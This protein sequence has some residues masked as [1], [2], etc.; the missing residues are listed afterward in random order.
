MSN[1]QISQ[2]NPK[3]TPVAATDQFGIDDNLAVAYKI[4]VANLQV[5]F[6]GQYVPITGGTMTGFLILNANPVLALGAATKQYVDSQVVSGGS[7]RVAW[8]ATTANL[9]AIY[10]NGT[11]G[12]GRT[13]TN[14]GA[15][16]TLSIDSVALTVGKK[17]LVKDQSSTFQN[18]LY[19]V[20]DI[21]SGATNWVLTGDELADTANEMIPGSETTI[22]Y[23]TVNSL[24]Q[25]L[26][27][28]TVV[29]VGTDPV[30]YQ[31]NIVAGTGLTRTNNTIALTS[32][33]TLALG[34]TSK[35]LT[36]SAGGIVWSDADSMEILAG[37]AVAGKMLQSGN[38][39]TPSWSTPTW[40][41]ASGVSGA[42][43]ISD[44]TNNVYS[45]SLWPNTVGASGKIILSNGTSNVYSTPTYPNAAGTAGKVIISDGTNFVTSTPTFPTT[46]GVAG[47]IVISDGTNKINSTS[48][49]PNT[50]GTA[51]KLVISDGTSNVYTTP[52]WPT[53]A[54]TSGSLVISDGT[55]KINS[56]S[57][58]PNT[59]GT[60]GKMVRSDGT[61][62]AY[63]TSTFADTYSASVLLYSNGA[64]TVTGLATAANGTLVTDG[65]GVPSISSTLP[66][67]VQAN[68][69]QLG[70]QAAALNMST[71]LINNVVDPVSAQDAATKNYVDLV[72]TGF[73]IQPACRVATTG[74]LS[75]TYANGSSGVGAT[76]TNNS[77]QVALSIDG[78]ALS[79]TNRVLVKDQTSTLQN[80]IYTVTTVG[81]GASNWV[82][83][84]AT[85]FDSPADIQP[86][87]FVIVNEGSTNSGSGWIETA[88]VTAVGTDPILFSL[89]SSQAAQSQ[90]NLI[91]GGN[92]DTNP[93]QR[94]VSF[95]LGTTQGYT[96]DRFTWANNGGTGG[97][98]ITKTAD[99]PTV[100]QAGILVTNCLKIAVTT[101]DVAVAAADL[102]SLFYKFE[103]Y[104][105][106]QL[107]QRT[108]TLSFWVKATV[109][110][111]YTVG[112]TNAVDRSY[113]GE[114]TVNTTLTWEKKTI[115]VAA[116]PSAGTWNYT[117]SEGLRVCFNLLT[118]ST[119][120]TTANA[121]QT[122]GPFF[123]TSN[124]VNA[125]SSNTNIFEL[126]LVKV[127]PG[128]FA[129]SYP[130]ECEEEV[131]GH[132]Q[133]Y[134]EKSY[135]QGVY[136]GAVTTVGIFLLAQNLLTGSSNSYSVPFSTQKRTTPTITV[137]ASGTGTSGSV[138]QDNGSDLAIDFA[139]GAMRS[140]QI[141]YTNG[142]ARY[143]GSGHY[144]ADAEL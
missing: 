57:L 68:I 137:Y 26:Q 132:C 32:P 67:A 39:V 61:V 37:V 107:A 10:D 139:F 9:T 72:A 73:N 43:I 118:G 96:A 2:L 40:P 95:A 108:F 34:G 42:I 126:A 70:A 30:L 12:E 58:W 82:L 102:Y 142:V 115:T 55:N 23:G 21:G 138:N 89:F 59:V 44:G 117:N 92:F 101:A 6:N 62:N 64:N 141:G 131:L 136:A 75:S 116:S 46:A 119:W 76:L 1:K 35:A 48:L 19:V 18:G 7:N 129:T 41:S 66:S 11:L 13:L 47:S 78:V 20:T 16:T 98:T 85:D 125:M 33:V 53:A 127:E 104:D 60:V 24:T 28:T 38:L 79:L 74:N 94:G 81:T 83:T 88:T 27:T 130:I 123:G 99:A 111:T 135:N 120:N 3:P 71:H 97:V 122:A 17:V 45:T 29:T 84:R 87:D 77:T 91:F 100:A 106:S 143:N 80:G 128:S 124:Q 15:Q 54:G 110:G 5:Y 56:T 25:W 90:E 144:T 103:G 14:N 114:Y 22:A 93:W 4:T 31:Y 109:T 69:T 52:T 134:Y 121:W 8:V 65:S 50:V 63:T 133:R 140:W 86:G 113:V 36:A 105:W 112:F 51:G 49:W